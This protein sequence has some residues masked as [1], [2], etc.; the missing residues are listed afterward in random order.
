MFGH[1]GMHF[2]SYICSYCEPIIAGLKLRSMSNNVG[3]NSDP[4][5]FGPPL[6]ARL[7]I[8]RQRSGGREWDGAP[9]PKKVVCTW[10][11]G[12]ADPSELARRLQTREQR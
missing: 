1:N 7:P 5:L 10:S 8:A 11:P 12:G 2:I 3:E 6:R 9:P 4:N